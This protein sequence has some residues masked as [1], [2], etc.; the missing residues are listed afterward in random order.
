MMHLPFQLPLPAADVLHIFN[1]NCSPHTS[2][3]VR[4]Y[5]L[6]GGRAPQQRLD[7][8]GLLREHSAAVSL[9]VSPAPQAQPRQRAVV[10][11]GR[12]GR[13]QA[14]RC[15]VVLFR[16]RMAQQGS[17][18]GPKGRAHGIAQMVWRGVLSG[19]Q[20]NPQSLRH[21]CELPLRH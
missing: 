13:I 20:V 14:Q 5:A 15:A 11:R 16:L 1:S 8:A 12:Q 9:R 7:T 10:V 17:R 19:M 18:N 6:P 21:T 3:Q 2:N 4:W